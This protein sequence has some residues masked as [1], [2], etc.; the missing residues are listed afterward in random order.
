MGIIFLDFVLGKSVLS[1]RLVFRI[2]YGRTAGIYEGFDPKGDAGSH[3]LRAD[4][5]G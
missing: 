1:A 2:S 5:Y 3:T 4:F